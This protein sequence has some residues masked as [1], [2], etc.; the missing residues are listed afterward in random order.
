MADDYVLTE[1]CKKNVANYVFEKLADVCYKLNETFN[2][3]RISSKLPELN[4][5]QLIDRVYLKKEMEKRDI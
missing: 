4:E 3:V 1:N 5:N 2:I